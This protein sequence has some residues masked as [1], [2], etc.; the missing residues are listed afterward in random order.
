MPRLARRMSTGTDSATQAGKLKRIF[1]WRTLSLS[2]QTLN[3]DLPNNRPECAMIIGP[4]GYDMKHPI[5]V[6][7]ISFAL[8][9]SAS[10]APTAAAADPSSP[11]A[12]NVPGA[13]TPAIH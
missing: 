10:T 3:I 1:A 13:A 11:A 5:A 12:S 4:K 9:Q 2:Q 8:A 7:L 6:A